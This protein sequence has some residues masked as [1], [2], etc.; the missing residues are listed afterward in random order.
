MPLSSKNTKIC[1]WS[2]LILPRSPTI[3]FLIGRSTSSIFRR[4]S[5]PRRPTTNQRAF[6]C[7][8]WLK[9]WSR[10]FPTKNWSSA[11]M[12][13]DSGRTSPVLKT[14]SA[15][16]RPKHNCREQNTSDSW[17]SSGMS[18]RGRLKIWARG[19]TLSPLR[20][21]WSRGRTRD[22]RTT[23]WSRRRR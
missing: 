11:R 14:S 13:S 21:A 20:I 9:L 2:T 8:S 16:P 15:N 10:S 3:D 1:S 12:S 5:A 22:W 4:W 7:R 17:H 18:L 19:R 23:S 6:L